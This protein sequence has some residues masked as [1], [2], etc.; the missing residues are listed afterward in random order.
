MADEKPSI[1]N[2]LASFFLGI[3]FIAIILLIFMG[4]FFAKMNILDSLQTNANEKLVSP[5][6]QKIKLTTYTND[7]YSISFP[8]NYEF[9]E[10]KIVSTGGFE[11]VQK[12]TIHLISPPLNDANENL[13]IILTY[14]KFTTFEEE[15]NQSS[16]CPE[17]FDLELETITLGN[18]KFTQ[19]GMINCGP[20]E[21]AFFYILNGDYIYEAKVET[22]ADY[23]TVALPQVLKILETI[24]FNK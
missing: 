23:S 15:A 20:N 2:I 8:E 22:T 9:Y 17:L 4:I 12:N 5:S 19:S 11:E 13:S 1:S 6:P 18:N 24:K 10:N 14:E 7:K 16:T 3:L 21:A